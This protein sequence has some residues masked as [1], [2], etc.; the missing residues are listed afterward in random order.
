MFDQIGTDRKP[1]YDG[2][3]FRSRM[4]DNFRMWVVFERGPEEVSP[5]ITPVTLPEPITEGLSELREAMEI[6]GLRWRAD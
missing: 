4:G 2:V 5:L 3:A 6:L 1:L